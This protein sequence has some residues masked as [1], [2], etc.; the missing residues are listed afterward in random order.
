[1]TSALAHIKPVIA[2]LV[3]IALF[4]C[5]PLS[6]QASKTQSTVNLTISAASSLQNALDAVDP[7][8]EQAHPDV[9]TSYNLGG[10]GTLQKQIE[11]GAPADI[12]LSASPKQMDELAKEGLIRTASRQDLLGNQLVLI[13][14]QDSP[15]TSFQD[16]SSFQVKAEKLA[17]GEFQSVPAGQYA[18]ATLEALNLLPDLTPQ[19]VFFSNVRGVLAAVESS[20]VSAG[21]VY[22]TDAQIS[23]KVKVVAIAPSN[24]HPPIRYPIAILQRSEH[25]DAAQQY[26]DFLTTP[27]ATQTFQSF[28]FTA[29]R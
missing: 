23:N 29:P 17:V 15:L 3:A 9:K 5:T 27:A 26:I 19:L 6:P 18:Q 25:P 12:F 2:S 11:Q 4:G 24:T 14:P 28:G 22:E 16:L 10:S 8:F 1:M 20:N 21:L 7:L 13:A